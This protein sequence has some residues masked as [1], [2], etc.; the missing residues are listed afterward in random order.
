MGAPHLFAY[1]DDFYHSGGDDQRVGI[2]LG[3][4]EGRGHGLGALRCD[5]AQV[6]HAAQAH[7]DER[8]AG[9]CQMKFEGETT[10]ISGRRERTSKPSSESQR[11]RSRPTS[12]S[13]PRAR[14]DPFEGPA[15]NLQCERS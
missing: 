11:G 13:P 15:P 2:R 7:L 6:D 5:P 12:G 1:G 8:P 10:S 14:E 4:Y 3:G 9:H